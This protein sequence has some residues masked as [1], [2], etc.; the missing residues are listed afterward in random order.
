[1]FS[2]IVAFD[3]NQVIGKDNKMPWHYPE[4]LSYFK[5]ITLG[6]KVVMGSNTRLKSQHF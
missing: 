5:R 6:K 4:D 1:M 3:K 2:I